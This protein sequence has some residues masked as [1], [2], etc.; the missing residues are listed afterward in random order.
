[1]AMYQQ[2][3]KQKPSK[4]FQLICSPSR[5]TELHTGQRKKCMY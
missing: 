4:T 3:H 2:T 5:N 1:M